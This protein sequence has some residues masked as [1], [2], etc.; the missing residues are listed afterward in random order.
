[1][2]YVLPILTADESVSLSLSSGNEG[3]RE[4]VNMYALCND[5]EEDSSN[6][7]MHYHARE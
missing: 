7:R 2:S 4:T 1:M 5:E 6:K 3:D